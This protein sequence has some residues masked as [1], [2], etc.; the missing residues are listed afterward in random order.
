MDDKNCMVWRLQVDKKIPIY[1]RKQ[2]K[3]E[4]CE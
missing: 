1:V 3:Y 4:V 2:N